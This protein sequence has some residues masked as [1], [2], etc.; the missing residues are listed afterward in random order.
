MGEANRLGRSGVLA[1]AVLFVV[2]AL[3]LAAVAQPTKAAFPGQNGDIA[4]AKF[5]PSSDSGR[6][7]TM[8]PDGSEQTVPEPGSSPSYSPDGMQIVFDR[9]VGNSEEE[10]N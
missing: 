4:Y 3:V 5:S 8:H 10:F 1:A 7:F 9:F 2:G 6:I